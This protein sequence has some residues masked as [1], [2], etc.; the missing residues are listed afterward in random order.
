M[1]WGRSANRCNFPNCRKELA[2]DISETD[3]IS[4]IGEECHIIAHEIRGPRGES[5]LTI[6]Q[7]DNY[8]NLIL[9][10]NNHHKIIDDQPI[11]YTTEKLAEIKSNHEVWVKD[12]LEYD[13]IK[14]RDD[15]VYSDYIEAWCKYIDIDNWLGWTSFM[16]SSGQPCISEEMNVQLDLLRKWLLSRI[17]PHRYKELEDSFENFRE[18][19]QDLYS[20]FHEHSNNNG[21]RFMTEKFY[22]IDHWDTEQTNNLLDQYN[23][24]VD[25]VQDLVLELTRSAN[26]ICDNIRKYI[27]PSFRLSEGILLVEYGPTME[28]EFHTVKTEYRGDQRKSKPYQGFKAFQS[29]RANRDFCFGDT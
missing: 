6:N 23:I 27:L 21:G 18:V 22:H 10:C 14:Q 15:E 25:L 7:R 3:D 16:L 5:D 26:Y 17:W 9:M 24:H 20:V 1:L 28:F 29:E 2:I 13:A 12:S 8:G 4:L 11:T 19:L